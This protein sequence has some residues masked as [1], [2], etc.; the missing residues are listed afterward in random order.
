MSEHRI[1]A[2]S[3][4]T[5]APARRDP[6]AV[7]RPLDLEEGARVWIYRSSQW[8]PG[9]VLASSL[10]AALVRYRPSDSRGTL[11]DT[12]VPADLAPRTEVDPPLDSS[13]AS[14]EGPAI[15]RELR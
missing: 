1:T 7:A 11:V 8:R 3:M 14:H 10:Q 2:T 15:S 6:A 9:R 4:P 5:M 12:A 13:S